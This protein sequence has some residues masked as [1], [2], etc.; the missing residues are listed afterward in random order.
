MPKHQVTNIARIKSLNVE[1]D[2]TK[3]F[4]R[5][6]F[7]K[8]CEINWDQMY[9]SSVVP[10]MCSLLTLRGFYLGASKQEKSCLVFFRWMVW[11]VK[12]FYRRLKNSKN[13]FR[14]FVFALPLQFSVLVEIY[15]IF[16]GALI[17]KCRVC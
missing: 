16:I 5:H 14:L 8:L 4:S 9:S 7:S 2:F 3:N 15:L 1:I 13:P 12:D 6:N 11:F 17:S 10:T